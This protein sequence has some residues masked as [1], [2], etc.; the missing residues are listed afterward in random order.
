MNSAELTYRITRGRRET[1]LVLS[2]HVSS[3]SS[4]DPCKSI[5]RKGSFIP[6]VGPDLSSEHPIRP[7]RIGQ[8]DRKQ[9]QRSDQKECLGARRRG[10]LPQGQLVGHDHRIQADGDASVG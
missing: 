8:N 1:F 4:L 7:T 5:C 2:L 9:E 6:H 3:P 10:S